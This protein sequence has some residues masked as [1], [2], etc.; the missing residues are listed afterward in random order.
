MNV[1]TLLVVV[2]LLTF[3]TVNSASADITPMDPF[4]GHRFE[5]FTS[6]LGSPIHVQTVEIFDGFVTVNNLTS[7]GSILVASGSSLGGD[8]VNAYSSP[9][10]IAQLGITE[11]VFHEPIVRFGAYFE[12]NSHVDDAVIEFF[13]EAGNLMSTQEITVS[14]SGQTW[15]WNGWDSGQPIHRA[16]VTGNNQTFLNGFIWF[17]DVQISHASAG[18][19][20]NRDGTVD[21]LDVGPFVDVMSSGSY[22]VE[23]DMNSDGVVNL[24]DVQPF[25]DA[26]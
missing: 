19:D 26:L 25:I 17:D 1:K 24:V 6:L 16:V 2:S 8:Q 5:D 22:Q 20:I 21:L 12:N 7:G 10:A 13:D 14:A 23:A 11:W 4:T 3:S 15:V 9:L 18:G